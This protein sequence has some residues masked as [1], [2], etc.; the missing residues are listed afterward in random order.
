MKMQILH[1]YAKNPLLS[2]KFA[3]LFVNSCI[4]DLDMLK[5]KNGKVF[6]CGFT[7]RFQRESAPRLGGVVCRINV[8]F[9]VQMMSKIRET[10]VNSVQ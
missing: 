3:L 4:Y 7:K 10:S 9:A 8:E 1:I 5:Y 2:T 6:K